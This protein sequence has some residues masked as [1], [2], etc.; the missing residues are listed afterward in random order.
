MEQACE[1]S[2]EGGQ[3]ADK[4]QQL[5]PPTFELNLKPHLRWSVEISYVV[6][7]AGNDW[8][9]VSAKRGQSLN[10]DKAED[11]IWGARI[12]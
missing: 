5:L 12:F 9:L 3:S 4:G 1:D 7:I 6:S 10:L 2:Q 8:R 11:F